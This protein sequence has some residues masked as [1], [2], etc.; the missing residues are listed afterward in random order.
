MPKKTDKQSASAPGQKDKPSKLFDVAKPG[1]TPAT[2]TSRPI[3]V[4][5]SSMIKKDPMVRE[6]VSESETTDP[7]DTPEEFQ[8]AIQTHS[9][10]KISPLKEEEID[11]EPAEN[12][13]AEPPAKEEEAPEAE[14]T[15][16][17]ETDPEKAAKNP[18]EE[19][20]KLEEEK[21]DE[22]VKSETGTVDALVGQVTAKREE[23]KQKEEAEAKVREIEKVIE[24]KEFYVPIG[25]E[26]RRRS[27]HRILAV[28]LLLVVLSAAGANFAID[29]EMLDLGVS[30]VTDLL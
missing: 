19:D 18:S 2:A 24:S 4:S 6:P 14:E 15:K 22:S 21:P 3:I 30:P 17:P 11:E 25:Q 16:L 8:I 23:Q 26:S 27:A 20:Q 9:A 12:I 10:A 5:H 29:A 1:E 28:L 13:P 7:A